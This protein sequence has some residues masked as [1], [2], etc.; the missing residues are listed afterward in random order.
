MS[1]QEEV[2]EA[3]GYRYT[4]G[5]L[6]G[7]DLPSTDTSRSRTVEVTFQRWLG[8]GGHPSGTVGWL[9]GPGVLGENPLDTV[10][11]SAHLEPDRSFCSIRSPSNGPF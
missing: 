10:V 7:K 5:G 1:N 11:G 8:R 9:H 2:T 4:G 3:A 6:G